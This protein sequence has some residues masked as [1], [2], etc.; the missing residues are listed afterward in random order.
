MGTATIRYV[1]AA[2]T[3]H[4]SDELSRIIAS[5]MVFFICLA[6]VMSL[7]FAVV[8]TVAWPSLHIPPS[9]RVTARSL[10]I[11]V[12][13]SQIL[14]AIPLSVFN[15]V[16]IGIDRLD[17]LNYLQ[18]G[19]L[20]LRVAATV[21]LLLLGYG[22]VAVAVSEGI[23]IIVFGIATCVAAARRLDDAHFNFRNA[24]WNMVR[25]MAPFSLQLF[26]IGSAALVILQGDSLIVSLFLPVAAV[27][28]YA[29]GYR[30]YQAIR[31]LTNAL[32]LALIPAATK[33]HVTEQMDHLQDL[34][35]RGTRYSNLLMLLFVVPGLVFADLVL[36]AWGGP[37]FGAGAIV[38]QILLASQLVNN[39]HLVA[40]SVL[41]GR[42]D[43]KHYAR[44][45]LLW[46][47]FNIILSIA[48]VQTIGL[49]GV[50]LGTAIPIVLLEPFYILTALRQLR[51]RPSDF[52]RG[53]V[54]PSFGCAIILG[55]PLWILSELLAVDTILGAIG[56]SAIW[57][58]AF[59]ALSYRVA[60][61]PADRRR[62]GLFVDRIRRIRTKV[63]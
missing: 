11:V 50:A 18:M 25:S 62:L 42:G 52:G 1:A 43:V 36:V 63:A 21:S 38:L 41:T 46:A 27:T 4:R 20:A 34:F 37:S 45:H 6:I 54:V 44:Y 8:M 12:G 19:Q 13:I 49:S 55:L 56:L 58:V 2:W 40:V 9:E 26:V 31:E 53:V 22:I 35:L 33:G 14:I 30:I 57:A 28:L 59:C 5:S 17:L 48:L 47:A 60:I 16:L 32:T 15:Q 7:A 24:R 23:L 39:N 51:L 3:A 61:D 29:A 10:L